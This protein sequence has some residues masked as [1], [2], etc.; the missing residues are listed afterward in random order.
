V[1]AVAAAAIAAAVAAALIPAAAVVAC[2]RKTVV[3]VVANAATVEASGR[4]RAS[5]KMP[6]HV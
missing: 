3:D 2:S 4:F 6:N 1:A 5:L